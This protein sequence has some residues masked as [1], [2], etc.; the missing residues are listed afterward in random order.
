M[1][2]QTVTDD[3]KKLFDEKFINLWWGLKLPGLGYDSPNEV[4]ERD[5]EQVKEYV[6]TYF[7]EA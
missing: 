1:S 7:E 6:N 5:P 2:K 3:L 4:W